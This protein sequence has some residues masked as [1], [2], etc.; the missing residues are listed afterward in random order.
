MGLPWWLSCEESTCQC[1]RHR[2]DSLMQEDST[3][4]R[5]TM[6]LCSRAQEPQLLKPTRP[7]ARAP[8]EKPPQ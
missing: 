8:Q 2:F 7:R 5:A 4:C 1:K 6:S 3:C